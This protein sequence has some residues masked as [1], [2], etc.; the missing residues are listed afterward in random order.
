MLTEECHDTELHAASRFILNRSE[1][2]MG[3]EIAVLP[4][5]P[6]SCYIQYLHF[7][8]KSIGCCK[9]CFSSWSP[10]AGKFNIKVINTG[11]ISWRVWWNC[12]DQGE[13]NILINN[14]NIK[15]TMLV[16]RPSFTMW[17]SH[18]SF[19]FFSYCPQN[20]SQNQNHFFFPQGSRKTGSNWFSEST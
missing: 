8:V 9:I 3:R 11:N 19:F 13:K 2:M 20:S 14:F 10:V 6:S 18:N 17:L 5:H 1:N 16:R 4:Q 15:F 7:S 12:N